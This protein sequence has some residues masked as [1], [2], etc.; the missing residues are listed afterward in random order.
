MLSGIAATTT[1]GAARRR[2]ANHA[3]RKTQRVLRLTGRQIFGFEE[4]DLADYLAVRDRAVRLIAAE[5]AY[6]AC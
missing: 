1:A 6:A 4:I 2:A 5:D 3:A